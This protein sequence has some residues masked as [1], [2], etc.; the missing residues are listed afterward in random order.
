VLAVPSTALAV[1]AVEEQATAAR[2][3]A[4]VAM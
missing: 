4:L 3:E 2:E 1:G